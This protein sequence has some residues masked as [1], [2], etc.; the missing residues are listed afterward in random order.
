MIAHPKKP[1]ILA[2]ICDENWDCLG[3][4]QKDYL[5]FLHSRQYTQEQIQRRLYLEHSDS[6]AKFKYRLKKQ[7]K[8]DL[9]KFVK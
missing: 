8:P 9:D 1:L 7:L 3:L 4:K 5:I 2:W 6:L